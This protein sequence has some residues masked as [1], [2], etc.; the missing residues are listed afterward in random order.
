MVHPQR[1]SDEKRPGRGHRRINPR[2]FATTGPRTPE[3][4][5]NNLLHR[6]LRQDGGGDQRG[7]SICRSRSRSFRDSLVSHEDR[8]LYPEWTASGPSSCDS[9][10]TDRWLP[11]KKY[12]RV[13][14]DLHRLVMATSC[15]HGRQT[16]GR[17][18]RPRKPGGGNPTSGVG[19]EGGEP[20]APTSAVRPMEV[21]RGIALAE[22]EHGGDVPGREPSGTSRL[23]VSNEDPQR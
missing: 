13:L 3:T 9:L 4:A 21:A 20:P 5:A 12:W 2:E 18:G 1:T 6:G 22:L 17:T 16:V 11:R 10:P 23:V 8:G 7:V 14:G 15:D 19:P